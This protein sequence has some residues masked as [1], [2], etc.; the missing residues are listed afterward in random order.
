MPSNE[1]S[2]WIKSSKQQGLSDAQIRS[3]LRE[4]GWNENQIN[5]ALPKPNRQKNFGKLGSS[6]NMNNKTTTLV[7]A[8]IF[9]LIIV[10]ATYYLSGI[11]GLPWVD[12]NTNSNTFSSSSSTT[13][14]EQLSAQSE[15]KK[16]DDYSQLVN[17]I[18]NNSSNSD[19]YG[20]SNFST[21]RSSELVMEAPSTGIQVDSS[22][23]KTL[24]LDT[25][26]LESTTLANPLSG[27]DYSGTNIQVLGVDESDIVKTDGQY[28]YTISNNNVHII[29]AYPAGN[30]SIISTIEFTNSLPQNLYLNENFLVIYGQENNIDE[31]PFY[32]LIR[33]Y[34]SYTFFKVFNIEDKTNPVQ[35]RDLEFEGNYQNS[36]MIGDYV[37]FITTQPTY[38]IDEN[39][40]LPMIVEDEQLLPIDTDVARCNCP[41]VYYIDAPYEYYNFTTVTAINIKDAN[42]KITSEAY[43][44]GGTENM[45]VSPEN[46]Y[47][48]YTKY[49]R[50]DLLAMEVLREMV[51]PNLSAKRQQ[52]IDDIE[53]TPSHVLSQSEKIIKVTLI[54]SRYMMNLPEQ[55]QET[56][57]EEMEKNIKAKYEDISKELEKTVIHKIAM[58]K[59]ELTYK[60]SGEVTG[61]ILNQFAMDE[62]NGYF[63]IATTKNRTW[64]SFEDTNTES[65]NNVYILDQDLQVVGSVEN[66]AEG[67]RI[68]SARFMQG[69][70]YLVT[71]H[72][73]DPLFVIDLKD[74]KNP[75]VLGEL[76]VPGFSSYLHPF[77]ETTL[78]GF[79]KQADEDGRVQGLKLSLFDVSDVNNLKEID[80]YEMGDNG[81]D[82]IAL[83][84]H[85]AFLFSGPK[86]LLVVPVSLR[87]QLTEKRY[88]GIYTRGAMI[89]EITKDGFTFREQ[90]NHGNDDGNSSD[91]Y[92]YGY[93]DTSVKRSMYIEDV[94]YTLSTKYLK[95]NKLDDLSEIKTLELEAKTS[96]DFIIR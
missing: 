20:I 48:A 39:Y 87:E 69:R 84:D 70:V 16:F 8:I 61:H 53:N 11:Y 46:I 74:P 42:K 56:L 95:M 50:E 7:L 34:S 29:E 30:S 64:S 73:T 47:I 4:A 23:G 15:L 27:Q 13:I 41:D 2:E 80:T 72:Q 19:Y 92:Y 43:L 5:E 93:Y 18:E 52:Q 62:Y 79:G 12:N 49:L 45:Y 3:Q 25:A 81:S 77:D 24:N 9:V 91:Y 38:D 75:V 57:Q 65:Y 28:V 10:V 96:G 32:D 85:K 26:D 14:D 31:K 35:V 33:P 82:S 36:R 90:I 37:Y 58:D 83:R 17:F 66:L 76:K 67:E 54:V 44:L 88:Q 94:L 63:R 21:S 59:D 51:Y 6:E 86:N 1:I 89:F 60:G 40:P 22:L 68:Y 55:E 78:I 71:F